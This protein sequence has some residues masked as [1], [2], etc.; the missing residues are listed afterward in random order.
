[1]RLLFNFFV[2]NDELLFIYINYIAFPDESQERKRQT[3]WKSSGLPAVWHGM[4]KTDF[5]ENCR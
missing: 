3:G 1:M 2:I 5:Y 4:K